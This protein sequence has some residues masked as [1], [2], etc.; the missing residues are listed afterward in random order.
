[1]KY[2]SKEWEL[3]KM[4][5]IFGSDFKGISLRKNLIEYANQQ[6]L[7]VEDL[8]ILDGSPLDFIDITKQLALKLNS[9]DVYGV[10][11]CNDGNGVAMAA[12]KF[13]FIRAALCSS[14][15]DAQAARKKLNSNVLCLGSKHVS[16]EQAKSCLDAFI[17][18]S[19]EADK[20]EN[21]VK[22]IGTFA[23]SHAEKGINLIVRAVIIYKGHIL[24]STTTHHNKEFEKDLYFLPGGHVE[25]NESAISALKREILE[26]IYLE[27]DELKFIGA[28]ECSWDKKG[29]IYHEINLVYHVNILNLSLE[30]PPKSSE[31]FIEFVW[32]PLSNLSQYH[33]LPE[34]LKPMLQEIA[35]NNN[36]PLFYSQML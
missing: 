15:Q 3:R 7:S 16:L 25:Y 4:S 34:Q 8:G 31:P 33:I 36:T 5:I 20:Y 24:L 10:L 22:K 11:I 32:R 9:P 2:R 12:N 27:V 13:N 6:D 18:T 26:E 19:F 17:K 21:S 14:E 28:L 35:K 30:A 1:M 29:K 23:T